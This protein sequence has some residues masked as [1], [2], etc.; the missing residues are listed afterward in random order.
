MWCIAAAVFLIVE[1]SGLCFGRV[2]EATLFAE[3]AKWIVMGAA[4][5]A[6]VCGLA[7]IPVSIYLQRK[8][9]E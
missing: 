2:I 5:A 8:G 3:V 9:D 7:W 4:V 1:A 6:L